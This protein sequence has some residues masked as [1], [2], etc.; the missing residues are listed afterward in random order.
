MKECIESN[1]WGKKG[2]NRSWWLLIGHHREKVLMWEFTSYSSGCF[3][4]HAGQRPRVDPPWHYYN[5]R[6]L[7][8]LFVD[9]LRVH[10]IQFEWDTMAVLIALQVWNCCKDSQIKSRRR[11][12]WCN[13]YLYGAHWSY[14]YKIFRHLAGGFGDFCILL[15]NTG[16]NNYTYKCVLYL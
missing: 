9:V 15:G 1:L 12:M 16:I 13:T 4:R 7:S 10:T 14:S 3:Y 11:C 6:C 8:S 5:K 2:K